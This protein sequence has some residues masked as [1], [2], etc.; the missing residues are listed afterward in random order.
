MSGGIGRLYQ[1]PIDQDVASGTIASG[2]L[3]VKA[4]GGKVAL[5]GGSNADCADVPVAATLDESS[6]D[7]DQALLA[8]GTISILASG[9]P[10]FLKADAGSYTFGQTVYL[11]NAVAGQ[12]DH[13]QNTTTATA[14]AIGVYLGPSKT[15][16]EGDLLLVNTNS[17]AW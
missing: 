4:S 3:L 13:T 8:G 5:A 17:G 2:G 16:L 6:R 14:L 11:S 15:A 12:I 1:D 10:M 9:G 7:A